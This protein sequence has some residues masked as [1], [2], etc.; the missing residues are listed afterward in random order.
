[1]SLLLVALLFAPQPRP[2]PP[3]LVRRAEFE[4]LVRHLDILPRSRR[5]IYVRITRCPPK[6]VYAYLPRPKGRGSADH[7][8]T[9]LALDPAEIACIRTHRNRISAIARPVGRRYYR[10]DLPRCR[11]PP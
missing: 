7:V 1:M 5:A 9:T 8:E 2:D 4:C 10:I 11:L 3:L 6:V